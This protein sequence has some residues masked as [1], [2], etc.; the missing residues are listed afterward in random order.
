M[1]TTTERFGIVTRF[2]RSA[3]CRIEREGVDK[4]SGRATLRV[5]YYDKD[6]Y[7]NAAVDLFA[8]DV[9]PVGYRPAPLD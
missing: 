7:H 6:G 3:P 4:K 9:L 2:G 1:T 8:E 5:R